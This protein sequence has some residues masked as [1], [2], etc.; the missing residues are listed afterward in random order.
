MRD[1]MRRRDREVSEV[2]DMI[3]IIDECDVCRVGMQDEDGMYIVPMNF[4]YEFEDG[5]LTFYFHGSKDGRKVDAIR[6]NSSVCFELDCAHELVEGEIACFYGF[7]YKSVFGV[8]KAEIVDDLEE[9]K[10]G[11]FLIM[12]HHTGKD[13]EIKD[14]MANSIAVT[15]L[16]AEWFTGKARTE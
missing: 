2:K 16:E 15:K 13:F 6:K 10:K 5:K 11:L 12:K 8:G 4:G 7:K 3:S 1:T 14:A 9:K